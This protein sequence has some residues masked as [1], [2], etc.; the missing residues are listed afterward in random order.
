MTALAIL[1]LVLAALLVA[2]TRAVWKANAREQE[3]HLELARLRSRV[4]PDVPIYEQMRGVE[5]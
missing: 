3:T 2:A 1:T 5:A 4:L